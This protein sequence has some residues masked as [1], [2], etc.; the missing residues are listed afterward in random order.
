MDLAKRLNEQL[1][2]QQQAKQK[3]SL[4]TPRPISPDGEP[5]SRSF[6]QRH[7]KNG[8]GMFYSSFCF[9]F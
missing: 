5:R 8:K 1:A 4:E 3:C 6:D 7:P 2:A 9:L